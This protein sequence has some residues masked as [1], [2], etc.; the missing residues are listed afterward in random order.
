MRVRFV[1][2]AGL[3]A[4]TAP[5]AAARTASVHVYFVHGEHGVTVHRLGPALT[6]ATVAVRALLA[7][8]TATERRQGLSSAVPIGTRLLGLSVRDGAASVDLSSRFG[9]GG[10]S[11]SMTERLAQLVYT[12]TAIRGVHTVNL[13]IEGRLVRVF[14]SEG[15]ILRQPLSRSAYPAFAR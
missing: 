2:I 15:L 9:S 3:L 5:A 7:G 6:P 14:G 1:V 12:L 8:P 11:L 10:G 4:L 13:R